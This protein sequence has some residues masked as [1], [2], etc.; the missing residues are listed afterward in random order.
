MGLFG[1]RSSPVG[2][3]VGGMVALAAGLGIG[4]FVY[5]PILPV[6]VGA[7]GLSGAQAGLIA[8]ANFLGYLLGALLAAMP[9]LPGS[10][11]GWLLGVLA[12][13]AITTGAMGFVSSILSFVMLRFVGGAAS[14]FVFVLASSVVLDGLA[15]VGRARLSSV[16]FAGVGVGIA[17]S[18]VTVSGALALGV[19]WR[20]LWFAVGAI[21]LCAVLAVGWLVPGDDGQRPRAAGV[22]ARPR[23]PD[24]GRL[25][26]AYGLFGFGYVVTATF[27]VAIV[28][29]TPAARGIEPLVW[30]VVGVTAVPSVALWSR[31]GARFGLRQAFGLACLVEAVGVA[32]S[33]SWPSATGALIAAALLGGTFVGLT[34]LGLA[35]ARVLAP[36]NPRPAFALMTAAFGL[37]QVVGPT[38]AGFLADWM[39]GFVVPSLLAAGALVVAAIVVQ[40]VPAVRAP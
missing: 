16:H 14:A 12:V 15:V 6:M 39:G 38:L 23:W 7:L 10:R 5:T 19:D 28:R 9:V 27:L 24:L 34:A 30:L 26:G 36:L 21:V 4:R 22:A 20:E 3:A 17:V 29:G 37:G 13:S 2:L 40:S 25:I 1:S 18:A 33:V 11:R 31:V 32:A 35:E 8:S